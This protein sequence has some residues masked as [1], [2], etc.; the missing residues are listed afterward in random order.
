[1]GLRSVSIEPRSCLLLRSDPSIVNFN[2]Q[3]S[4][5]IRLAAIV[6]INGL[7]RKIIIALI[8]KTGHARSFFCFIT[9]SWWYR[10]QTWTSVFFVFVFW[11]LKGIGSKPDGST[12]QILRTVTKQKPMPNNKTRLGMVLCFI[13]GFSSWGPHLSMIFT[14]Y[15]STFPMNTVFWSLAW[16]PVSVTLSMIWTF[17]AA[18]S[19]ARCVPY[20]EPAE[21]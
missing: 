9:A 2:S 10:N 13:I 3:G 20:A 1:M 21:W 19:S 6:S 8:G 16:A 11:S 17:A 14:N 4:L 12:P 7:S 5:V 15:F 18:A